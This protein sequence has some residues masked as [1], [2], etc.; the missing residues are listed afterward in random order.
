MD[1]SFFPFLF[2]RRVVSAIAGL[3][4]AKNLAGKVPRLIQI[5][6]RPPS[7]E[8]SRRS[9]NTIRRQRESPIRI[10][11]AR[12]TFHPHAQRSVTADL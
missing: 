10:P 4:E 8:K 6:L 9:V 7:F 2:P 11:K 1:S 3:E 5:F 12:S